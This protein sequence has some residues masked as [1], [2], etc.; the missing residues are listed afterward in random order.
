MPAMQNV[1]PVLRRW[2]LV[3][4]LC[5]L[6]ARPAAAAPAVPRPVLYAAIGA[7]ESV[8]V[9]ANNPAR[10]SWVADLARRLP[11]GSRLLNLGKSGA[12]LSYGVQSELPAAVAA[13]PSLVTVWMAVNDIN[14][15]VSPDAY[16]QQLDTLLG[17]L[18]RR[19]HA[20]VYVGNVPDLTIM[21]LYSSLDKAALMGVIRTYNG[22]ISAAA[23]AH[24][25]T[26]ID[27]FT[28]TQRTLPK[29]PEYL[30]GDGFHPSTAGYANIADLWWSV[31]RS[32]Q[33]VAR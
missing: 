29:H 4:P 17:T 20:A 24:H 8:G 27:I 11:R 33:P 12:L 7:S 1:V 15:R 14:G 31:I 22:I 9:G 26:V 10:E 19:T 23:R 25:A 32:H 30:S 21:P 28:Q 2:M 3:F 5:F 16:R 13:H 18:Q 6:L